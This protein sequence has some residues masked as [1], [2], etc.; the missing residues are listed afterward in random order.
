MNTERIEETVSAA[1]DG[2]PVDLEELR[3]ALRTAQ[4]RDAL[5]AFVI[6]RSAAASD[7]MAPSAQHGPASLAQLSRARQ[8]RLTPFGARAGLA[9]AASLILCA[10]VGAFWIGSR[11][12]TTAVTVRLT[13]PKMMEP[14]VVRAP[15]PVVD[16][17]PVVAPCPA[18]PQLQ[19]PS[20]TRV[21]RY[22]RG[23]DWSEGTTQ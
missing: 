3:Q 13:P 6:L 18:P 19:P 15:A 23:V 1:L 16:E 2:E 12:Q 9:L 10:L 7:R 4:G 8:R 11:W 17:R 14:V 22:V 5:A 21:V 20:P